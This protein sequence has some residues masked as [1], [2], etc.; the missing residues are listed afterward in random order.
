MPRV[1]LIGS[2]HM[3]RVVNHLEK[4]PPPFPIFPAAQSG[5]RA[6][7]AVN[8]LKKH[9]WEIFRFQPTHAIL[10]LGGCDLLPKTVDQD[11]GMVG[12]MI[13]HLEGVQKW[14]KETFKVQVLYSE[15][16]PHAVWEGRPRDLS[17]KKFAEQKRWKK[18]NMKVLHIRK[19]NYSNKLDNIIHHPDL[20]EDE[21]GKAKTAKRSLFDTKSERYWGLHLNEAGTR[22]LW[23]DFLKA[24]R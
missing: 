17:D 24:L 8:F 22:L 19:S 14:L 16:L 11:V 15:L 4:S 3:V 2:S 18:H 7:E 21:A 6:D 20:W 1:L 10:H 9:Q 5:L 12:V 13:S 23:D